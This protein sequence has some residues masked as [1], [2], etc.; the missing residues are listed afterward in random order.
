V[1]ATAHI[2]TVYENRGTDR[3]DPYVID[4]GKFLVG[5]SCG[6]YSGEVES[7]AEAFEAARSHTKDVRPEVESLFPD[8]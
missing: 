7:E 6:W 2:A 4:K 5:C 1:T 3:Y 8:R